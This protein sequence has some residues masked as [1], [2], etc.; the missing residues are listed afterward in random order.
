MNVLI[1]ALAWTVMI[2]IAGILVWMIALVVLVGGA[3]ALKFLNAVVGWALYFFYLAMDY[4]S[5]ET[6]FSSSPGGFECTP[7]P[8]EP[9]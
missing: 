4:N 8:P 9:Y 6:K 1:D 7:R 3:L 2:T 5:S